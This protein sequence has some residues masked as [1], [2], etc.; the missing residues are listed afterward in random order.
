MIGASQKNGNPLLTSQAGSKSIQ[1]IA[2]NPLMA[3]S[4]QTLL[5]IRKDLSQDK[6]EAL[7]WFD[8]ERDHI[9]RS[10]IEQGEQSSTLKKEDQDSIIAMGAPDSTKNV[11]DIKMASILE[12]ETS[13]QRV[14]NL[15]E[16]SR[17]SEFLKNPHS[18]PDDAPQWIETGQDNQKLVGDF[19]KPDSKPKG[20]STSES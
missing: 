5:S 12:D 4:D 2:Q 3:N 10:F 18:I 15:D 17:T 7:D 11:N 14:K 16:I 1:N 8:Q 20:I 19:E 9:D 6:R 13:F